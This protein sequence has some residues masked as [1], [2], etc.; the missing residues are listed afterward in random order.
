MRTYA[1]AFAVFIL[2]VSARAQIA[3]PTPDQ[4]NAAIAQGIEGRGR[5][6]GLLLADNFSQFAQAFGELGAS[7]GKLQPGTHVSASGFQVTIFTPLQWVAE[8]ASEAAGQGVNF[9]P[10]DVTTDILRPVL[11]VVATP[12]TPPDV[13]TNWGFDVSDVVNVVLKDASQR[14][15][16]EPS[17]AAPFAF[18]GLQGLLAEF[19]LDDLATIRARNPEFYVVVFGRGNNQKAFKVKKKHFSRLP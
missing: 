2:S 18:Q 6:Q 15:A 14:L 19:S 9:G 10:N 12:S 17:D 7:Q 11:H 4:I 8:K 13:G 1:I 16:V 5:S 3:N